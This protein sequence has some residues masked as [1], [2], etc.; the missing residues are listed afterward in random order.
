[1]HTSILDNIGY[2]Y[3]NAPQNTYVKNALGDVALRLTATDPDQVLLL[4]LSI[5]T[6]IGNELL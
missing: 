4:F 1:M 3:E 6:L 5:I 2:I